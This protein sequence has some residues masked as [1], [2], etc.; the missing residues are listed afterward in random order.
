MS[1]FR[2]LALPV[3]AAALL[4]AAGAASAADAPRPDHKFMADHAKT[5]NVVVLPG[6]QYQVLKSGPADGAH[7]TRR[8][9]VTVKYAGSFTDGKPFDSSDNAPG[10]TVTFPLGQL[11]PGW[12]AG[13][14]LMRP[15]D[16]WMF[17]IPS[18]LAYGEKGIGPI[19]P[20]SVL[21]FKVE[22]VSFA[23]HVEAKKP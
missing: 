15:G 4:G 13:I 3:L 19:P 20:N 22:L 8:D 6:I 17:W 5:K 23:P 2:R 7:P 12:V 16:V 18:E 21:V 14:Q 9:D 10:G 11:I 1:A